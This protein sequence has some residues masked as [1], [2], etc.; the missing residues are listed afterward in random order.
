[1]NID[2]I[3]KLKPHLSL[4]HHLPGRL[5]LR[6]GRTFAAAGLAGALDGLGPVPGVHAVTVNRITGSVLIEY[7]AE[8]LPASLVQGLFEEAEEDD[9]RRIA[10]TLWPT[11]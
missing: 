4:V 7:D 1:M 10:T 3:K 6:A 2:L 11:G 8:A 9:L 5:R